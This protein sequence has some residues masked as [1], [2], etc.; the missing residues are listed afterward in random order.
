[1]LVDCDPDGFC[2]RW[3]EKRRNDRPTIHGI[4][5][6]VTSS[7]VDLMERSSGAVIF[8]L[9]ARVSYNEIAD[10]THVADSVLIPIVPSEIDVYA[11]TRFIAR[12]LLDVGMDRRDNK[13]AIVANRVRTNT[14]SY[15]RLRRFLGSLKVPMIA[16]LRDTQNYVTAA[17]NGIGICEL[18]SYQVKDDMEHWLAIE[19]WLNRQSGHRFEAEIAR[20]LKYL[21]R[22]GCRMEAPLR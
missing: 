6:D 9:P 2:T 14:R 8:D 13:L 7:D 12:L 18:P 21:A 10:Y 20:E 22:W 17:H 5:P 3:L 1:M 11:A 16:A 4:G 19:R 15:Q